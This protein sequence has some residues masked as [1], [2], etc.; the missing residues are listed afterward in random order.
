M[1]KVI[2]R[3]RD[4][5]TNSD[6]LSY[7]RSCSQEECFPHYDNCSENMLTNPGCMSRYCCGLSLCNAAVVTRTPAAP[8]RVWTVVGVGVLIT[9]FLSRVRGISESP[10]LDT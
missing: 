1:Q 9:M 4:T 7:T 8:A 5:E 2:Y 6:Y 3:G 10:V